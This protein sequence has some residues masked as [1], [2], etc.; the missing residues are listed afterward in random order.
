[1]EQGNTVNF[2]MGT[3]EQRK[4]KLGNKATRNFIGEQGNKAPILE[5]IQVLQWPNVL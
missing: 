2:I 5:Y 4:T 1:M 3:R